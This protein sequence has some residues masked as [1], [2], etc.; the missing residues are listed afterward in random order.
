MSSNCKELKI[1]CDTTFVHRANWR[2]HA[3]KLLRQVWCGLVVE[4]LPPKNPNSRPK[5]CQKA[6]MS[7]NFRDKSYFYKKRVWYRH[8]AP[9]ILLRKRRSEVICLTSFYAARIEM[10]PSVLSMLLSSSIDMGS[11]VTRFSK[12][13][14]A[15]TVKPD[16][17]LL[18]L[19]V[20]ENISLQVTVMHIILM[21][22]NE[23]S[24]AVQ[25]ILLGPYLYFHTLF[26]IRLHTHTYI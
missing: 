12:W 24:N 20:Y 15:H 6:N 8:Q 9:Y 2:K 26:P 5:L 1:K 14:S 19:V 13:F 18:V 4:I 11:H 16:C 17:I 21:S 22:K 23:I 7:S 25:S 10:L 3:L